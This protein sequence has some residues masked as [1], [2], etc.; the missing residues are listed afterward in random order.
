M[1]IRQSPL[2]TQST[3]TRVLSGLKADLSRQ[4]EVAITGMEVLDP[5]DAA[6]QWET[7][8]G[9]QAGFD[10]QDVYIGNARAAQGILATLDDALGGASEVLVQ[11]LELAVQASNEVYDDEYRA[12]AADEV[13]MMIEQ[14]VSLGN[15]EYADRYV[16]AGT[17]YDQPAFADDGTYLGNTDAPTMTV[18]AGVEVEVGVIGSDAF[19][20]A[21]QVLED[22]AA[23][24]RSG[25]G[26]AAATAALLDPL[27]SAH[28]TMV[29]ARQEAGFE[30][31]DAQEAELTAETMRITLQDALN[32]RVAADPIEALT[33]LS[34]LQSAYETA[35]QVTA[36]TSSS[37]L[38]EYLR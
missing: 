16:F 4:T 36:Q 24:L 20:D 34:E 30:F 7:I 31:V 33:K 21:L 27:E 11:A 26:S 23:A 17:A 22:L 35:L 14:L 29:E 8:H 5:H 19:A 10:D 2:L 12:Q 1:I 3:T 28:D 9:L 13:D 32:A 37:S 18:G 25:P 38:F 15:T 6:G